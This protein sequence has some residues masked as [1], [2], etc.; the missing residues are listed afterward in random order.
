MT[1]SIAD[2]AA[3]GVPID[4]VT[5]PVVFFI[6]SMIGVL[7][8][9]WGAFKVLAGVR[10]QI[11]N[12]GNDLKSELSQIRV[13][14]AREHPTKVDVEKVEARLGRVENRVTRLEAKGESG[15]ISPS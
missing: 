4:S 1:G 2:V 13:E 12:L 11:T 14:I 5:M 7:S 9:A 6:T 15:A 8:V 10:E 3:T